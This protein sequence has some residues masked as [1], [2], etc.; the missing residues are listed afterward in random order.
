MSFLDKL[1]EATETAA[2][3]AKLEVESL[4]KRRELTQALADLGRETVELVEAGTVTEPS[5]AEGAERIKRLRAEL[6][7][8]T[9]GESTEPPADAE[10]S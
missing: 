2:A 5:L 4:Q 8:L 9:A 1:R 10:P 7:A 6:E 3:R